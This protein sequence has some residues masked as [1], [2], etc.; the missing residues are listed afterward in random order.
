VDKRREST[1]TVALQDAAFEPP[2]KT[3]PQIDEIA[4]GER[5]AGHGAG[6]LLCAD[7]PVRES[8]RQRFPF[9]Q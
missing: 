3:I 4:D 7:N 8:G 9:G 5:I 1:R 2:K 6:G